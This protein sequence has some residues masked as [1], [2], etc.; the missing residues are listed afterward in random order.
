MAV[1]VL[2]STKELFTDPLTHEIQN[3]NFIKKKPADR[4]AGFLFIDL[5][6]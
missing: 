5:I 3:K 6:L 2:F 1:C 4:S